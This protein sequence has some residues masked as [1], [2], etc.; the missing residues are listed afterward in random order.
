MQEKKEALTASLHWNAARWLKNLSHIFALFRAGHYSCPSK[1]S[2]KVTGMTTTSTGLCQFSLLTAV[3]SCRGLKMR[4]KSIMLQRAARLLSNDWRCHERWAWIL[5]KTVG[6]LLAFRVIQ[7]TT[8]VIHPQT[9][10]VFPCWSSN[11]L[12]VLVFG[13]NP[14]G[15]QLA[16]GWGGDAI[17]WLGWN[18]E[19]YLTKF[20]SAGHKTQLAAWSWRDFSWNELSVKATGA[21]HVCFPLDGLWWLHVTFSFFNSFTFTS[22]TF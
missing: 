9:M 20:F 4:E 2:C 14:T 12:F 10:L 1:R 15:I 5:Q 11:W 6:P 7:I 17:K 18:I 13:L 8:E 3:P 22:T 19:V 21:D 16:S